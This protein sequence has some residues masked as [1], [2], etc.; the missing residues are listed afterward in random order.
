MENRLPTLQMQPKTLLPCLFSHDI[1]KLLNEFF[2]V[3][4]LMQEFTNSRFK[5]QMKEYMPF[6]QTCKSFNYFTIN[7]HAKR[8]TILRLHYNR[9]ISQSNY[10]G[11]T[12]GNPFKV[13]PV[14]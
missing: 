2:K 7:Y 13:E 8:I 14:I 10:A 5:P 4:G 12:S 3:I 6:V 9:D 11:S 1:N